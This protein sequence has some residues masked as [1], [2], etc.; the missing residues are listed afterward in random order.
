MNLF[1]RK[2]AA[3]VACGWSLIWLGYYLYSGNFPNRHFVNIIL[4]GLALIVLIWVSVQVWLD[5]RQKR[6]QDK[7]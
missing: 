1:N 5:A 4:V 2:L 3:A 7:L 6:S